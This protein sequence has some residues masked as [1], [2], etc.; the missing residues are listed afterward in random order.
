MPWNP[1]QYHKF[2]AERSAPFDDLLQL[3]HVRTGMRV[4]DL[5][6]PVFYPFKRTFVFAIQ[7][8]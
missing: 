5:G 1:T 4:V 7:H 8:G 6:Q 3:V 2:S